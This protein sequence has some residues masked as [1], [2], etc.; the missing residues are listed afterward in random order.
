[1]VFLL[2]TADQLE[3]SAFELSGD[4]TFELTYLSYPATKD[5]TYATAPPADDLL[6]TFTL[7]P[8]TVTTISEREGCSAGHTVAFMLSAV[9]SSYLNY[10]QDSNPCRKCPTFI[11]ADHH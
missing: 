6:N 11:L 9:G 10:F 3:T 4:A 7:K 5:T 8:G 2:P 1:M